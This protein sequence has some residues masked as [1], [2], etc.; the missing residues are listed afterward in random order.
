VVQVYV[1]ENRA[2]TRQIIERAGNAGV[3]TLVLTVDTPRSPKKEWN[4]RNGFSV[5]VRGSVAGA[6]D[7]LAH[8]RWSMSVLLRYLANGGIPNYAHYP[9]SHRTSIAQSVPED[10][11]LA[12][13]LTWDD[14]VELR[15]HWNGKLVIKGIL[16]VEDARLAVSHGCDGIVVSS[17][18]ARNF[19]SA[20]SVVD[21]L[22]VI[23]GAVGDRLTVFADSGVRR[24]SDIVKY[25]SL[26]ARAVFCGRAPLYGVAVNGAMG[27]RDVLRN[28]L[29]AQYEIGQT[30]N[31]SWSASDAVAIAE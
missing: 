27:A 3:D 9:S 17:H 12:A 15:R 22:P 2:L 14:V 26:G 10:V 5:P 8:P 24:G 20:P 19:D 28:R 1:F 21:L 11:K 18:G 29:G 23:A 4:V 30:L 25:M 16:D 7:V 6:I 31:L 13:S